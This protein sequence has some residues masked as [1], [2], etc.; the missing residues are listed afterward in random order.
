MA[1]HNQIVRNSDC[2]LDFLNL[3]VTPPNC[4][5]LGSEILEFMDLREDFIRNLNSDSYM[6]Y[7]KA[8]VE[9]QHHDREP[10]PYTPADQYDLDMVRGRRPILARMRKDARI[11]CWTLTNGSAT[12]VMELAQ[13]IGFFKPF[14]LE[15]ACTKCQA[16]NKRGTCKPADLS[17]GGL[18]FRCSTCGVRSTLN[19]SQSDGVWSWLERVPIRKQMAAYWHFCLGSSV[20]HVCLTLDLSRNS[21]Y[22]M[23]HQFV[24]L[25]ATHQEQANEDLTIGGEGV[26]CEADE[27][28]F[29]C[30]IEH[31]SDSNE[32]LVWLRYFGMVKRGSSNIFLAK[33]PDRQVTGSGQGGGGALSIEEL[34]SVLKADSDRPRLLPRSVLHTDSARAYRQVGRWHLPP[35]GPL[36]SRFEASDRFSRHEWSHTSVTHKKKPGQPIRYVVLTRVTLANGSSVACK[37]GTEKVDGYWATLRRSVGKVSQ[38]TGDHADAPSRRHLHKLVRTHQWRYWHLS[39]DRFALLGEIIKKRR[40]SAHVASQVN[41]EPFDAEL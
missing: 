21:V 31:D 2:S 24:N 30:V 15:Y 16:N 23:Y 7:I 37:A 9:E 12:E 17:N 25:V 35:A 29:R 18:G 27:I 3:C 40:L 26:Q 19:A 4:Q 6:T 41:D 38:N 39:E 10:V 13:E 20:A 1:L 34:S 8:N 22:S 5:K 32:V 28:A 11:S 33:L 36:Q 14:S